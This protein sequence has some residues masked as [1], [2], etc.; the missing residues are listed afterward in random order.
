MPV[1]VTSFTTLPAGLIL[2]L[3]CVGVFTE[4]TIPIILLISDVEFEET[5][6]K[7]PSLCNFTKLPIVKLE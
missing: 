2:I 1:K 6:A 5:T 7:V 3:P 4:L